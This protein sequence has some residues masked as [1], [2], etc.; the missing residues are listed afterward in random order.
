MKYFEEAKVVTAEE[1]L[2]IIGEEYTNPTIE[3][4]M[5]LETKAK[6]ERPG[7]VFPC[8]VEG[9]FLEGGN[10]EIGFVCCLVQKNGDGF[11]M[12]E[13][14]IRAAELGVNK[15]FWD[16]PPKKAVRDETS[17]LDTEVVQ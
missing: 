17:W 8:Y 4:L 16:K 13:V 3:R 7:K 1:L 15:R 14:R 5:F 2:E 11:G 9:Y 12:I 10:E 6:E